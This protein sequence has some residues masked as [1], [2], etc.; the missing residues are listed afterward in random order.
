MGG[1]D[2]PVTRERLSI[3]LAAPFVL[4]LGASVVAW[5]W[6]SLDLPGSVG[7]LT[8]PSIV[9]LA[10][11]VAAA[12]YALKH[13]LPL[14]MITWLPAGQGAVVLL[15]TG[16]V[17]RANDP[18]AGIAV[19][20]AYTFIFLIVLGISLVV[21]GQSASLAVAFV[22]FFVMTQATRFP[23]FDADASI[24]ISGASL[25]TL[26]ALLRATAE[27]VLL[28]WLARRLIEV[29]EG[30]GWRVAAAIVGLVAAHGLF[31]SWEDP[32]LRG[33][34]S[35]LE[36]AEQW[37]RWMILAGIQ[38]GMAIALIRLRVSWAY[39]PRLLDPL[40]EPEPEP[41]PELDAV[42]PAHEPEPSVER[43]VRRVGRPTPRRHR[44]R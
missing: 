10:A 37:F 22:S 32:V 18:F 7:A 31:A 35:L 8:P 23:V 2:Q 4:L 28:I 29:P 42:E 20:L 41:E 5:P 9:L 11:A 12:M 15:T 14:G 43:P 16:I 26:L 21:A 17:T 36:V 40:P 19:I 6:R 38:M 3:T 13:G 24:E 34:F 27:L 30:G 33:E 44:R 1:G 25:L 39:D